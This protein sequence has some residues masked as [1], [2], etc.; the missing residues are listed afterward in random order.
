M[1]CRDA[2]AFL[3]IGPAFLSAQQSDES[4]LLETTLLNLQAAAAR[5]RQPQRWLVSQGFGYLVKACL[6]HWRPRCTAR[7]KSHDAELFTT[8]AQRAGQ[9]IKWCGDRLDDD[10]EDDFDHNPARG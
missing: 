7:R 2:V 4:F 5:H 10:I 1:G 9:Q 8:A 3:D 6:G